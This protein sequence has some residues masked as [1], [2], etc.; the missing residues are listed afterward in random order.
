LR[1]FDRA[2]ARHKQSYAH[3]DEAGHAFRL[4]AGHRFRD[5]AGRGSD[6]M[7]ATGRMLPR[8][9]GMMFRL[10]GLVKRGVGSILSGWRFDGSLDER[11][12]GGGGECGRSA[13]SPAL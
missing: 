1:F 6:L 2:S 5:E 12:L 9:A 11:G 4:E 10:S 13:L 8:I 7:S 3:S